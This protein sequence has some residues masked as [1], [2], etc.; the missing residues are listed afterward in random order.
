MG[1]VKKPTKDEGGKSKFST[2]NLNAVF[3][4]APPKPAV[5]AGAYLVGLIASQLRN[6]STDGHAYGDIRSQ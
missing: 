6:S 1:S 3:K 2:L 5:T 4:T